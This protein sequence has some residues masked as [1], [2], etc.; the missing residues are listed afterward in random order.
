MNNN[1]NIF[2]IYDPR[3]DILLEKRSLSNRKNTL[4]GLRLAILDNSKWNAN[5]ILRGSASALSQDIKFSKVNYYV[6]KHGFSTDATIEMIEEIVNALEDRG[7]P[8]APVITTEFVNETKLTRVAI[9]MPDLK[10]V[11]ID[12]PVSSIT[13]DEDYQRTS[14]GS[15]AWTKTRYLIFK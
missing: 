4:E 6:K 8:A 15:L 3:G 11:V 7:I 14:T 2:K 5:K 1:K 13:N 12:H 10:P 9:G